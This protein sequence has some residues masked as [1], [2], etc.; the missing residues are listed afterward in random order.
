MKVW[1]VIEY[2]DYE[3]YCTPIGVFSSFER[4]LEAGNNEIA[5]RL[6]GPSLMHLEPEN[7]SMFEYELDEPCDDPKD[8]A[9]IKP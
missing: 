3:G 4:A 1:V 5:R 8:V 7:L 2:V 9:V 6:P